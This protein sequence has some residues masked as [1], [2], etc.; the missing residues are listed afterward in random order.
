[1]DR[2]LFIYDSVT[3][4]FS[5]SAWAGCANPLMELLIRLPLLNFRALGYTAE[6]VYI[7]QW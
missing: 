5:F 2:R 6:V 1:V 4:S 7:Q 3:L